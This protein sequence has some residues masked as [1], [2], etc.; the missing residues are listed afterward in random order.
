MVYRYRTI[1]ST[2][3]GYHLLMCRNQLTKADNIN[4]GYRLGCNC[5][6]ISGLI[7]IR[8]GYQY[9]SDMVS[10]I[11]YTN[12]LP[13]PRRLKQQAH[14]RHTLPPTTKIRIRIQWSMY[15]QTCTRQPVAK[16]YATPT[17]PEPKLVTLIPIKLKYIGYRRSIWVIGVLP[18]FLLVMV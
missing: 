10:R 4:I 13:P 18:I 9:I 14:T 5:G 11:T 1:S 8:S 12:H 6:R 3:M 7:S 2:G 17:E 15:R 16:Y